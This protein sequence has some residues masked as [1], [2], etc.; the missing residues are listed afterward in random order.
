[1]IVN[2]RR[3]FVP[4]EIE[5]FEERQRALACHGKGS[6]RGVATKQTNE[7]SPEIAPKVDGASAYSRDKITGKPRTRK[8]RGGAVR[9]VPDLR[10]TRSI[11]DQHQEASLELSWMRPGRQ[12]DRLGPA[13]G[14]SQ[15]QSGLRHARLR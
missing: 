5:E 6:A 4:R 12:R 9:T 10:R 8:P 1:V 13:S 11:F 3:Y 15:L 14:W 7:T 2:S